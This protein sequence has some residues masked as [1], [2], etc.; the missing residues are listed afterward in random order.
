V[1]VDYDRGWGDP[2]APGSNAGEAYRKAH[3]ITLA[4]AGIRIAVHKDIARLVNGFIRE[5][6]AG[7][8]DLAD[9][10]DDWGYAHRAIRGYEAEYARTKSLRYLSNHSR[11]LAL[12]LNA[13]QHPLG[14]HGTGIPLEVIDAARRWGFSWG[15]NYVSRPD[16]MHFEFLGRPEDVD[17]YPLNQPQSAEGDEPM[18]TPIP[19]VIPPRNP[20]GT[21][22]AGIDFQFDLVSSVQIVANDDPARTPIRAVVQPCRNPFVPSMAAVSFASLDPGPVGEG[23]VTL[24]VEHRPA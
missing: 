11:G 18:R 9:V 13:T 5:I 23:T 19:V 22:V 1:T 20:S 8:F 2:G 6:V 21:Q 14:H 17:R 15:G 16:E 3:I 4:V 24:I 12:D 7:G 10:A